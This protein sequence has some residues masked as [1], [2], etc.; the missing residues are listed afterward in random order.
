MKSHSW[1]MP[2]H[3]YPKAEGFRPAPTKLPGPM[4]YRSY[5]QVT[6]LELCESF[7]GG[8]KGY[9][10]KPETYYY[11]FTGVRNIILQVEGFQM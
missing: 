8:S 7:Q 10:S 6:N 3:A 4:S 2:G 9:F 5:L 1:I 11:I